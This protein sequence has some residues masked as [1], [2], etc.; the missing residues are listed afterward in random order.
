MLKHH[1]NKF[2]MNNIKRKT[3][4]LKFFVQYLTIMPSVFLIINFLILRYL[5][6]K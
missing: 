5:H 4:K 1:F 6:Y 2:D 3:E